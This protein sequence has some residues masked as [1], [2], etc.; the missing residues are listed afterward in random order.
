VA[1]LCELGSEYASYLNKDV[2][3]TEHSS[4]V[5]VPWLVTVFLKWV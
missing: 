2:E 5:R 4:P 3:W 1:S